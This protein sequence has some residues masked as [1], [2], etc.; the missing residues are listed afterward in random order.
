MRTFARKTFGV[1]TGGLL[2]GAL[3]LSALLTSQTVLAATGSEQKV[4][5]KINAERRRHDL[6]AL[7]LNEK[8]SQVARNWSR[9]MAAYGRVSHNDNLPHQ[10]RNWD[11]E[12]L[13]ENVGRAGTVSAVFDEFRRSEYHEAEM[14]DRK[15]WQMGVGVV[16]ADGYAWVTVIYYD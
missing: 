13:G 14:L 12:Y 7:R 8:L 6:K 2:V 11:W 5:D 4:A 3:L 15:W 9:H 1:G 10:L 16:Y